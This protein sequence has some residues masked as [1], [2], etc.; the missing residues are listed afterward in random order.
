MAIKNNYLIILLIGSRAGE[1]VERP[2]SIIKEL[3]EK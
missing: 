1:I 3:V 2:A